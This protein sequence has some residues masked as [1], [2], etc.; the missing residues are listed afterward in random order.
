MKVLTS[1]FILQ[2]Q[3]ICALLF[4]NASAG[5]PKISEVIP[6]RDS[7]T[8]M[9]WKEG[10]P[11]KVKNAPWHRCISGRDFV[12]VL[13]TEKIE[14]PHLGRVK[15]GK[16]AEIDTLPSAELVLSITLNGVVYRC[17]GAEPFERNTGPRI[18]ESGH[19][20]QR[21]DVTDLIFESPEGKVLNLKSRFETSAWANRLSFV[22]YVE[23]S[24]EIE[25]AN[26]VMKI[27]L[28]NASGSI[29]QSAKFSEQ[30]KVSLV[31]DPVRLKKLPAKQVVKVS[32]KERGSAQELPVS[33]E[34]ELGWHKVDLTSIKAQKREAGSYFESTL[35]TLTNSSGSEQTVPVMFYKSKVPGITGITATIRDMQGLPTGIPVQISKNWHGQVKLPPHSGAWFRGVSVINVPAKSSIQLEFV[36]SN[37]HWGGVPAASHAQL[38]LI[39]WGGNQLWEQSALGSWGESICY[40]PDQVLASSLITD[41]RPLMLRLS[42]KDK[43]WQWTGNVGGGDYMKFFTPSGDRVFHSS[44]RTV[45][46]KQGPCLTEVKYEGNIEQ[47]INHSI[48]TSISRTDDLVRGT[49]RIKM[50]VDKAIKFSRLAIFQIGADTYNMSPEKTFAAGDLTNGLIEEWKPVRGNSTYTKTPQEY[51]GETPWFSLH[52]AEDTNK[53]Q[54]VLANRG[55]IIRSWKAKL[56]GQKVAPWVGEY[57]VVR[58]ER[59]FSILDL[60]PPPSVTELLPGDYVEAV[61]EYVVMPKKAA[62]YYGPNRGFKDALNKAGNTY[63][64]IAREAKYNSHRVKVNKGT[65]VHTFPDVRIKSDGERANFQ[66]SGGLGYVP[67]TFTNLSSHSGYTL[68][69][70]GKVVDQSVHGNDFW[71]TDFDVETRTWS[72]TYNVKLTGI[73]T[74]RIELIHTPNSK[75]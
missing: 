31:F 12:M 22:L 52:D 39:G 25:L 67:L 9:W 58:G 53:I 24:E 6:Q 38:S 62:H 68:K 45:R 40:E 18:I 41:V 65:L 42:P 26:A 46:H 59:E 20:F 51:A 74:H 47:K 36:Y 23:P 2:F 32:A 3:L 57:A 28:S 37:G 64:M 7:Y 30:G 73:K 21:A 71:Q 5:Q 63:N 48:T 19:F 35:F 10:M 14:I 49:Y 61:I 17:A 13:D 16:V 33:Y 44:V 1:L 11:A 34:H 29:E 8:D 4:M 70:D 60:T 56:G 50:K 43:Q 69:V 54:M 55:F 66:F 27:A 75:R 15:S 72:I